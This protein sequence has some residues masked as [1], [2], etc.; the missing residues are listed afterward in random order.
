MIYLLD[1]LRRPQ[2]L[3]V[4]EQHAAVYGGIYMKGDG[5]GHVA[6]RALYGGL[7]DIPCV[8]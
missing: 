5:Y 8:S 7:V 6:P 2:G 4:S 3:W 1:L